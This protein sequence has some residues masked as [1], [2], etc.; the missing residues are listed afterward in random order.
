M[1]GIETIVE[2]NAWRAAMP[3]AEALAARCFDAARRRAPARQS[4]AHHLTDD[5]TV[6]ALKLRFRGVDKPTN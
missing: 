2:A 6:G 3:D 1:I 5:A 4:A